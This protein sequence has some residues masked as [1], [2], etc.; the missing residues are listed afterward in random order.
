MINHFFTGQGYGQGQ[1]Q[2]QAKVQ[3]KVNCSLP[4][5][6][7]SDVSAVSVYFACNV[8][9]FHWFEEQIYTYLVYVDTFL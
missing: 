9:S 2:C 6:T 3:V 4:L 1:G 5:T 8:Y 7:Y